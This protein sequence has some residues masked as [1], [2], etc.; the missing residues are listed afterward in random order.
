MTIMKKLLTFAHRGEAQ[1]FQS[2]YHFKPV[3]FFFDGLFESDAF[4]LLITGEGP[5]NASE[6]TTSVLAKF[7]NSID[8]VF[9][10][11]VAGSLNPKLKKND[12]VWV[13][14]AFAHHAE[15]LE[16]KSYT[17]ALASASIDCMT[18]YNRV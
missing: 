6:K 15:R 3:D 18:A 16:F 13:R 12:L 17:S 5:H 14:T 10:I 9:N 1:A 11:G 2:A 4:F 8:E 7:S